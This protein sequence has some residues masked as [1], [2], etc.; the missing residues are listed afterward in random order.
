MDISNCSGYYQV[1]KRERQSEYDISFSGSRIFSLICLV[2][3][4]MRIIR[5]YIH[6]YI[7]TFKSHLI[8]KKAYTCIWHYV[9]YVE[10][11]SLRM[12]DSTREQCKR[13]PV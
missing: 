8:R 7:H 3:E 12:S 9:K 5:T 11:Y 1:L 6:T 13:Y 10:S 4:Y 2:K